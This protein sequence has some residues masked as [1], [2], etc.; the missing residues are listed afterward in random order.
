MKIRKVGKQRESRGG[1]VSR[2]FVWAIVVGASAWSQLSL[3]PSSPAAAAKE[4]DPSAP[5]F[6][7]VVQE[8]FAHWD[9]NH[10]GRLEAKEID[11]LMNRK[12]IHRHAAAALATIKRH[13]R[14]G[15]GGAAAPICSQRG[16]AGQRT[17]QRGPLEPLDT[18][19][20]K[21]KVYHFEQQ[22]KHNLAVL[23][24]INHK[25]YAGDGPSFAAMHQGPI[26]DCYFFCVTGYLA[27]RDPS[28]SSG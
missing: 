5:T 13:E 8:N 28:G 26:G 20:G 3:L 25:L 6:A 17:C 18:A 15:A 11:Q 27:D 2:E 19:Q 10:D 1:H 14:H 16:R 4:T 12:G 24:S 23:A 9:L 7:K 22:F 21:P